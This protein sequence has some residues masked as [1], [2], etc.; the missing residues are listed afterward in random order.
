MLKQAGLSVEGMDIEPE[1]LEI[2]R[3]QHSGTSFFTPGPDN[4]TPRRDAS[5]DLVFLS[6]VLLFIPDRNLT[7]KVMKESFQGIKRGW[8]RPCRYGI[9]SPVRKGTTVAIYQSGAQA[10]NAPEQW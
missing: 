8:N 6:Y 9:R 2:A 5:Y 7:T 3:L 1:M 10:S 4:T